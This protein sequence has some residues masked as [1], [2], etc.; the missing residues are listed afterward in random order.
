MPS[1]KYS[2]YTPIHSHTLPYTPIH[3]HTLPYTPI[4]SIHSH[5]IPIFPY[6]PVHSR[7]IRYTSVH[8]E[9][10][11][12]ALARGSTYEVSDELV[13]EI[14][15]LVRY[16]H[17][18]HYHHHHHLPLSSTIYHLPL[19]KQHGGDNLLFRYQHLLSTRSS[20][21]HHLSKAKE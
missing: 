19:H 16:Y 1:P 14:S 3:S 2:P 4:H 12:H 6:T 7:T 15:S 8:P 18:H 9:L 13:L 10:P 17:H 21:C 5:N 20:T 11:S